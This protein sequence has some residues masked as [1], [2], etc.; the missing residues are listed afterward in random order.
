MNIMIYLLYMVQ[1]LYCPLHSIVVYIDYMR[2]KSNMKTQIHRVFI[3]IE[4]F[5]KLDVLVVIT[6]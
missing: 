2:T 3:Y 4:P 1:V 6:Y 5:Q